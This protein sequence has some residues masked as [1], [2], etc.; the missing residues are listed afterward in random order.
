MTEKGRAGCAT[1]RRARTRSQHGPRQPVACWLWKQ[2]AAVADASGGLASRRGRKARHTLKCQ[3]ACALL[4]RALAHPAVACGGPT[5][6]DR[7]AGGLKSCCSDG[8]WL[9]RPRKVLEARPTRV[10]ALVFAAS[11]E[12]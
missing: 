2:V 12:E 8:A 1:T 5:T 10:R 9:W 7:G 11:V 4:H 3:G 6:R